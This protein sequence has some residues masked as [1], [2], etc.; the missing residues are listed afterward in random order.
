MQSHHC[1]SNGSTVLRD[2]HFSLKAIVSSA[3]K[4]TNKLLSNYKTNNHLVLN[5]T[6][7]IIIMKTS[8][9]LCEH[10]AEFMA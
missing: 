4:Q 1:K 9:Q 7:I 2:V 6:L 10:F 5:E 8:D 3:Q